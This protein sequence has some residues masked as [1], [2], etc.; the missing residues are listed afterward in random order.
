MLVKDNII[1]H[2]RKC[3]TFHETWEVLKGLYNWVLFLKNKLFSIKMEENENISNFLSRI[4]EMKVKLSDTG[5]KISSTDLVTIMLNGT[6]DK[7]Q[8][9]I[10]SLAARGK[11]TSIDDLI[12]IL[13]QEEDRRKNINNE[14][15]S[16]DLASYFLIFIDDR[17][18]LT[19]VYFIRKKT[20]VFEYFKEFKNK[21]E[22]HQDP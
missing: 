10:N 14:F 2:I 15:L 1:P 4:K 18:R 20:D 16:S 5:E 21:Q 3:K 12:G 11:M 8:I 19:W 7:Y 6:L 17:T 22:T 13:L 9:F